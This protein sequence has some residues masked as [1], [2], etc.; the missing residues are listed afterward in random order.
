MISRKVVLSFPPEM[1]DK[2]IISRLVKEYNLEFNILKAQIRQNE[3]G[4]LVL[5]LTGSADQLKK[6][7]EYLEK[8]GVIIEPLSKDV[9]R[10]EDK[11]VSCGVCVPQ[12]PTDALYVNTETSEVVFDNEKCIAC[13]TCVRVCPYNAFEIRW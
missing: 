1:V 10:D 13:E 11:C 7:M 3:E 9:V 2:P 12:C 8:G 5:E 4:L 6:G